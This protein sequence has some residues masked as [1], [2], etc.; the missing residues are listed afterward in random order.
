MPFIPLGAAVISVPLMI[1]LRKA[2]VRRRRE[3]GRQVEGPPLALMLLLFI[4][5]P[6]IGTVLFWPLLAPEARLVR[7]Y[8]VFALIALALLLAAVIAVVSWRKS[9][10]RVDSGTWWDTATRLAAR[11]GVALRRVYIL[12]TDGVNGFALP[13]GCVGLT[14]GLVE[15]L[16]PRLVEAIIAH[17]LG[18]LRHRHGRTRGLMGF[19]VTAAIWTPLMWIPGTVRSHLS[20]ELNIVI[21]TTIVLIAPLVAVLTLGPLMRRHERQADRFAAEL[22]G[23]PEVVAEALILL[24]RLTEEPARLKPADEAIQTHPSLAGRLEALRALSRG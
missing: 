15:K 10:T 8:L 7:T 18:H 21:Q 19:L 14:R 17:E 23:D 6:L 3:A 22:L 20:V 9:W 13:F 4:A 5:L 12:E 1:A 16:E 11:A 2:Y 24:H